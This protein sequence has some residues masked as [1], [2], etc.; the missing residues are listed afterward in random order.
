MF[1]FLCLIAGFSMCLFFRAPKLFCFL[2]FAYFRRNG[3]AFFV[4]SC[5]KQGKKWQKKVG[6][7]FKDYDWK[8]C[9]IFSVSAI[10]FAPIIDFFC[11]VKQF[12]ICTRFRRM[13]CAF[14]RFVCLFLFNFFATYMNFFTLFKKYSPFS[15]FFLIF[16]LQCFVFC[17]ESFQVFSNV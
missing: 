7:I 9:L 15:V 16:L 3:G 12:L 4:F 1:C 8:I 5:N 11:A 17:D 10:I 6:R 14:L 13:L 2:Y